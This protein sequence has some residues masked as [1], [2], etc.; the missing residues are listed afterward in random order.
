MA[1]FETLQDFASHLLNDS[2][3]LSAFQTDPEGVLQTAGLGD[4]S[5]LDVQEILPLVLDHS[6]VQ[7][8]G[9]LSTVL[10]S[11]STDNA[12]G[13]LGGLGFQDTGVT[14]ALSGVTATAQQLTGQF[15][16]V[17]DLGQ[18]LDA[19]VLGDSLD[20][21]HGLT[22]QGGIT[23]VV[24]DITAQG[25]VTDIVGD[26]TSGTDV[27]DTT[28]VTG[29]VQDIT[30]GLGTGDVLGGD[31]LGGGLSGFGDIAQAGDVLGGVGHVGDVTSGIGGVSGVGDLG[32]VADLH[33][34]D[35]GDI[36]VG[37]VLS[38]N[39]IAF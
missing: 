39:A 10:G 26:L 12:L 8:L 23:D 33:N 19:D 11:L 30:T 36:G 21:V 5:A 9:D 35:L 34:V 25:Q 20:S 37:D 18:G 32:H 2:Q 29:A 1:T 16:A 38:D 28:Q 31:V 24:G 4:V 7:G 15:S 27:L 13:V 6:P 17:T 22:A 14:G 3:A